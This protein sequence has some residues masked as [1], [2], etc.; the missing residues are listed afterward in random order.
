MAATERI[1]NE[2]RM[3]S[4][5]T[6]TKSD[7]SIM[8]ASTWVIV[9]HHL[10]KLTSSCQE[11]SKVSWHYFAS[12]FRPD[13]PVKENPPTPR[14]EGMI[15]EVSD[16]VA[17]ALLTQ[18]DV[19]QYAGL[20]AAHPYFLKLFSRYHG[21][22]FNQYLSTSVIP[23]D[24]SNAV[25]FLLHKKGRNNRRLI[26]AISDSPVLSASQLRGWLTDYHSSPRP[27]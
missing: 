22:L 8:K 1:N 9:A 11:P 15:M 16:E 2:G 4:A 26:I 12:V 25:I 24:W 3:V 13:D 18:L 21:A 10:L 20:D 17:I 14:F 23:A 27:R 6:D 19:A 7:S 5:I